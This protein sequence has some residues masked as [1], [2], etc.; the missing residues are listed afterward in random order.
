M[1]DKIAVL[2]PYYNKAK[3]IEKVVDDFRQAFQ[4]QSYMRMTIIP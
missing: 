2:V 1:M 3:M 4:K